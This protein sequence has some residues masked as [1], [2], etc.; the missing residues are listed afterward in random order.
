MPKVADWSAIEAEIIKID[1]QIAD[2][3]KA[4]ADKNEAVNQ[5][6]DALLQR[7][8]EINALRQKQQNIL[9]KAK[10]AATQVAFEA[11]AKQRE[12]INR[13]ALA[14]QDIN[15]DKANIEARENAVE[16]LKTDIEQK[17]KEAESLRKQWF[18]ENEKEYQSGGGD[19][20]CP[21]FNIKCT[22]EHA[23]ALHTQNAEKAWETFYV[24]KNATLA[25]ITEKGKKI[26]D[27]ISRSETAVKDD[28]ANLE[29]AKEQL[30]N[31]EDSLA[32]LRRQLAETPAVSETPV[33]PKECIEISEQ[34]IELEKT[35]HDVEPA[36]VTAL[37]AQ[38]KDL[39]SARDSLMSELKNRDL[40]ER[41]TGEISKL[42]AQGKDLAQQIADAEREEFIA[43]Q[44]TKTRIEECTNRINGL[45]SHVTFRLFKYTIEGNESETCEALVNGV[46][47]KVANTAGQINA[48]LDIINVLT[49][50]YD[51]SAPIFIDRRESVNE[52]IPTES[53]IINL[54]VSKDKE[55]IIK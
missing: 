18:A 20:T 49:K 41:Y 14:T 40:I 39:T 32:Q 51:V 17:K 25:E 11:N 23:L 48:G 55:L 42:E 50:F 31:K 38:K 22:C 53:Q 43:Q 5:Q 34:I 9:N 2:I 44:F 28:T 24:T 12:L 30:K 46:P 19:L 47:F 4:I 54:V 21:A 15:I 27:S 3:D 52:L 10:I 8:V 16:S 6:N 45:F 35:M 29:D 7:Q 37:Q 1:K 36:N 13:I 33:S 26:V